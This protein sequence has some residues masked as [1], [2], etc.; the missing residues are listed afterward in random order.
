MKFLKD[1]LIID[2]EGVDGDRLTQ[3]GAVLLD[4][5]TLEEK[6]NFLSYIYADLGSEPCPRSGI[7]QEMINDAPTQA[8]VGK[9]I[10]DKFGTDIILGSWVANVDHYDFK[11]IMVSASIDEKLYDYHYFDIWPVAYAYLVKKGYKGEMVSDE[12]FREFGFSQRGNHNGL[13]DAR[14]AA[15]IL[16]KIMFDK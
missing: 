15:E 4:K 5:E 8:E 9:Q 12:M 14:I 13:E 6:D 7:T 10:F 2:F 11:K 1:L 16:R 3:I